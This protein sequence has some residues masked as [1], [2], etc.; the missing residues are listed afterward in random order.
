MSSANREKAQ[1]LGVFYG[2]LDLDVLRTMMGWEKAEVASLAGEL[3]ETGL[4][5]PDPYNHLTLNPALC[6]YVRGQMDADQIS[7]L[8]V[9]WGEAMRGYADFLVQSQ[10]TEQVEL[11][12][13]LTVLEVPNFFVLLE[14]AQRAGDAAA[15]IDL[16]TSLYSLLQNAGKPR[17]VERVARIRD[18]AAAALEGTWNRAS[19]N[20]RRTRIE[21][22]LVSSRLVEAL[23]GAQ[24]LLQRARAAGEEAY[25]WPT[26]IWRWPVGSWPGCWRAPVRQSRPC[27]CWMRPRNDSR[28]LRGRRPI[29]VRSG[30][31]PSA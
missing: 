20:A 31:R 9:R 27:R 3:I 18:A 25:P 10:S 21:E 13:M 23:D 19:F 22:Q 4:A 12:A 5:T 11:A 8:T 1:V 28:R 2:A 14:Q 24:Q 7:T 6:P 17:L 15:T 30:W 26:T 16:A 29:A